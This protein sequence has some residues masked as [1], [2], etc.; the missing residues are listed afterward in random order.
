MIDQYSDGMIEA[1]VYQRAKLG[2][3]CCGDDYYMV[4]TSEYF[5]CAVVDGLGSGR[6]ARRAATA[7]T[8]VIEHN[9]HLSGQRI[10]DLC[11]TALVN[12]RGVVI[13]IVKIDFKVQKIF[14]TNVGN[15][16]FSLQM[17]NGNVIR[18]I[19]TQG[20]LS[21]RKYPL[22]TQEYTYDNGTLFMVCS[23]GVS[24]KLDRELIEAVETSPQL[25]LTET[26]SKCQPIKDDLTF[27][28][29]KL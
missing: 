11:N 24:G 20:Y 25:V 28:V 16:K 1:V 6:E 19:P 21:G 3:D 26:I 2:N 4:R 22:V 7:A 17:A 18:P 23:D 5:L 29:G 8:S 13:T 14:Y 12:K 15:T 27:I 9:H 10:I